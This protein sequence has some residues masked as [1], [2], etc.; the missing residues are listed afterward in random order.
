MVTCR[1]RSR[2]SESEPAQSSPAPCRS[3]MAGHENLGQTRRRAGRERTP[4]GKLISDSSL[5]VGFD[6]RV[7]AHL[8]V[9]IGAKL[10]R[11]ESFTVS[12][13]DDG[14]LGDGRTSIRI[15]PAVPLV[16][17]SFGCSSRSAGG[18]RRS[19]A[20]GS[21][22]WRRMSVVARRVGAAAAHGG[23]RGAR[24]CPRASTPGGRDASARRAATCPT[25]SAPT[26][27]TGRAT[28]CSCASTTPI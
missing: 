20:A 9:G 12:W 23:R 2:R 16:F 13:K 28:P 17:K 7:I 14:Q 6:D 24:A 3:G 15:H 4:A 1:V 21:R 22:R 5:T 18:L 11:G 10:R 26:A 8:Q 27:T 25:P 19:T